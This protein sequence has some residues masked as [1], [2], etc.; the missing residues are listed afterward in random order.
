MSP[1][2]YGKILS[3]YGF[4]VKRVTDSLRAPESARPATERLSHRTDGSR[5]IPVIVSL[6]MSFLSSLSL[7]PYKSK[8][9]VEVEERK[10][11]FYNRRWSYEKTRDSL[12]CVFRSKD[13]SE[14]DLVEVR[15][16]R[17]Q[18]RNRLDCR[19]QL[20]DKFLPC[21]KIRLQYRPNAGKVDVCIVMDKFVP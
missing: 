17:R 19:R 14:T 4:Q 15:H 7:I 9:R 18:R 16:V 6:F 21:W 1:E 12:S 2:K 11:T 13:A 3:K 8:S 5:R 20:T 10:L